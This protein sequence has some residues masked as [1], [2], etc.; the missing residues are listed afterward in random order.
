MKVDLFSYKPF[1]HNNLPIKQNVLQL[2][3]TQSKTT[4]E[5]VLTSTLVYI[6]TV[7]YIA[8]HLLDNLDKI[9]YLVTYNEMNSVVFM[10]SDSRDKGQPLGKIIAYLRTYDFP[11]KQD[12][13]E[14]LTNFN[15][16]R[17]KV[18]HNLLSLTPEE[19]QKIDASL[20]DLAAIAERIVQKYDTIVRGIINTWNSYISIVITRLN[21]IKPSPSSSTIPSSQP[22]SPLPVSSQPEPL[23][24]I[25]VPKQANLPQKKRK[26]KKKK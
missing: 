18:V 23:P 20:A 5:G 14:E 25:V 17:T 12:F 15:K 21:A 16:I 3:R 2:A 6:N 24:D 22:S 1:E 11:G 8:S 19:L 7:D 4:I 26:L 9:T 13:L 10:E